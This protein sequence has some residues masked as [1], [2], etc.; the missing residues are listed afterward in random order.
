MLG[1]PKWLKID[2]VN[3]RDLIYWSKILDH[4]VALDD[5]VDLT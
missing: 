2:E 4:M 1:R 5:K 3:I